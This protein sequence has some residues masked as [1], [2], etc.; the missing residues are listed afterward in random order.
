LKD[1]Q[2]LHAPASN[3]SKIDPNKEAEIKVPVN[4]KNFEGNYNTQSTNRVTGQ[5]V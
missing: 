1:A 3:V 4:S 5:L 2:Q